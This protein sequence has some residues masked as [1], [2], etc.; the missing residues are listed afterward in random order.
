MREYFSHDYTARTDQSLVML[1]MKMG[2]EGI[3][4][5]WCL[6]EILYENEGR[7]KIDSVEAIAYELQTECERIKLVLNDFSLFKFKNDYIY[8]D[9]VNRRLKLRNEKSYKATQSATIRWE[10]ERKRRADAMRTHSDGNAIKLK[11]SKVK[12]SKNIVE[13]VKE[14]EIQILSINNSESI[15]SDLEIQKF[16]SYWTEYGEK[17]KKFRQEKETTW[18][19]K[20]RLERWALN[21]KNYGK[22]KGDNGEI[23]S[24]IRRGPDYSIPW[25]VALEK[26]KADIAARRKAKKIS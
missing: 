11:E 23:Q 12:E 6:V 4:I 13:R 10:K 19:S 17:S 2:M 8:S 18:D 20:K 14:F 5:Y 26:H 15:L 3:G 22:N 21:G 7:I 16:I 9:S 24:D 1:R 25:D